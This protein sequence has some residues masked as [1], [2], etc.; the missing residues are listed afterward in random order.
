MLV[1]KEFWLYLEMVFLDFSVQEIKMHLRIVL[2]KLSD[3]DF[4]FA[5]ISYLFFYIKNFI[6]FLFNDI[7][8]FLSFDLPK[9]SVY[10]EYY[11]TATQCGTYNHKQVDMMI[12]LEVKQCCGRSRPWPFYDQSWSTTWEVGPLVVLGLS[13]I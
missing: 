9:K 8:Y 2:Q 5:T 7:Q 10:H 3:F 13:T 11:L 12:S 6:K 1:G 4:D